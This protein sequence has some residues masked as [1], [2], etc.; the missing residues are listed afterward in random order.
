MSKNYVIIPPGTVATKTL[1]PLSTKKVLR[2][3]GWGN[4]EEALA[5]IE[6]PK[7]ERREKTKSAKPSNNGWA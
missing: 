2:V 7:P 6:T 1:K 5:S 3:N 4:L